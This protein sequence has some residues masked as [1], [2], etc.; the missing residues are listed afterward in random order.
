MRGNGRSQLHAAAQSGGRKAQTKKI[1]S[2]MF[3]GNNLTFRE[4]DEVVVISP[5][6]HPYYGK[7]FR[8]VSHEISSNHPAQKRN[9]HLAKLER[10]QIAH[11][12]VYQ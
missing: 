6:N 1:F 4:Q 9:V 7:Y 11:A 2:A 12:E 10:S 8:V 3:W 5:P